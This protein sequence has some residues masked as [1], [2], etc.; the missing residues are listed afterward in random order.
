MGIQPDSIEGFEVPSEFLA[1]LNSKLAVNDY[2]IRAV[3]IGT[4]A[5]L[6]FNRVKAE[7]RLLDHS[8]EAAWRFI[9]ASGIGLPAAYKDAGGSLVNLVVGPG[10]TSTSPNPAGMGVVLGSGHEGLAVGVTFADAPAAVIIHVP[11]GFTA[12]ISGIWM[13]AHRTVPQAI[14]LLRMQVEATGQ[15]FS[16]S[17]LWAIMAPGA[18]RHALDANGLAKLPVAESKSFV[19]RVYGAERPY[20]LDLSQYFRQLLENG[21]KGVEAGEEDGIPK[22]QIDFD[23]RDTLTDRDE[24]GNYTLPSKRRADAMGDHRYASGLLAVVIN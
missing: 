23:P 15:N 24:N 17:D 19:A 4:A 18:R 21:E 20:A 3:K 16:E 14:A 22:S 9:A 5:G 8:F 11:T 2:G 6:D 13:H 12:A 1:V 7:P 10:Y